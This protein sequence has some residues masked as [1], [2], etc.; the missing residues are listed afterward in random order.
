MG[1]ASGLDSPS[2]HRWKWG[3]KSALELV[4]DLLLPKVRDGMLSG[5]FLPM[6]KHVSATRI[7]DVREVSYFG[8]PKINSTW[9]EAIGLLIIPSFKI[10]SISPT[11]SPKQNCQILFH[12]ILVKM[13]PMFQSPLV[14]QHRYLLVVYFLI[15]TQ[16]LLVF[17]P[18][19][20]S[21]ACPYQRPLP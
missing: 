16:Q 11:R 10:S 8:V 17:Y 15:S 14:Y 13:I 7:K 20:S 4:Q 19:P 12:E 9:F 21:T 6:L 5:L 18:H 2:F 1:P 3:K